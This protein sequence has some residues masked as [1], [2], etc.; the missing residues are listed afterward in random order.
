MKIFKL[1]PVMLLLYT[2]AQAQYSFPKSAKEDKARIM[3][4]AYWKIWNPQVQAQIDKDIEKNRKADGAFSLTDIA[5][6][7]EIRIEQISHDFIFGAHIFNFNQ[8]GKAEYNEKY[9]ELYGTLFNSAT[10]AFYWKTFE[11]QPNRQRFKEEYW[12]T[13][14][15][16][17]NVKD[18]KNEPHWRRPSPEPVIE[19]CE[20]KGIHLNGH[21]I[22]WGNRKWNNP[23]WILQKYLTPEEKVEMDKLISKYGDS[24][25]V[26]DHEKYSEAF[27]ALNP[28]QL[29]QMFP[30]FT[31]KLKHL[32][33]KRIVELAGYY[34]DRIGSWDVVN[35]SATDYEQG[36]MVPGN[37]ICKSLYG[38]MPGDYAY[39]AFKVTN[40]V[41]P[42]NVQLG[43]SDF[44][45]S[46]S[47][48]DLT[49]DLLSRGC[50]VDI[51][52]AHM[53]LFN[54]QQCLDIAAGK[55]MQTPSH[56][57]GWTERLGKTGLPIHLSE[58]TITSPGNNAHGREIQAVIAQNLYRLWFS[59]E[60]MMGITWW[61]VV[62]DCGAPG[63]PSMS[64]IFTR[65]MV[66]KPAYYALDNLINNEWKTNLTAKPDKDGQVKFRGFK[67]NYLITWKDKN[68]N[69]Q[70][71]EYYLK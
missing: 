36:R 61:N 33:E 52:G 4:E 71:K 69:T 64:G 47:Y 60:P 27:E 37:G 6:D 11:M 48:T 23:N 32:F 15:Y 62:D 41:F 26:L 40:K 42:E 17:N 34:G 29:E 21:P 12:D 46:Q 49:N 57:W 30:D 2:S 35:E 28:E 19:F 70:T 13:E 20:S 43:I 24:N 55:E 50:R 5:L 1:L 18:P 31:K 38:I 25:N 8:L 56:I 14:E 65:E 39:E 54:P 3:S 67:G 51:M 16:W 22:I 63:E 45:M 7:T 44:N 68:G 66:A 59:I 9:K 53:H 10:I 58:I